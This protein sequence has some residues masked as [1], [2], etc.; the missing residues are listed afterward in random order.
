M[1]V[2]DLV[3]NNDTFLDNPYKNIIER[4]RKNATA[5]SNKKEVILYKNTKNETY[6]KKKGYSYARFLDELYSNT[7]PAIFSLDP[8]RMTFFCSYHKEPC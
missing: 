7:K 4:K 3:F 2:C 5:P 8:K 1:F 6:L